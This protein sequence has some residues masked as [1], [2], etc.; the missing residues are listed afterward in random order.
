MLWTLAWFSQL[1]TRVVWTTCALQ[2]QL[3]S[4]HESSKLFSVC[5][6]FDFK[7]QFQ[8]QNEPIK[9]DTVLIFSKD[10]KLLRTFGAGM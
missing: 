7:H 6:S 1:T 10:G 4:M 9:E 5:R 2:A 3:V 8:F